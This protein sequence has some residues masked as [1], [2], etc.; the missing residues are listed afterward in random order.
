MLMFG[1][2]SAVLAGALAGVVAA[3][4][5]GVTG[6]DVGN[7]SVAAPEAGV[8]TGWEADA[9][10]AVVGTGFFGGEATTA[11]AG[12][13]AAGVAAVAVGAAAL[14]G[15][16]VPGGWPAGPVFSSIGVDAADVADVVGGTRSPV[17]WTQPESTTAVAR[18]RPSLHPGRAGAAL[19][20]RQSCSS[21]SVIKALRT[22]F[23]WL[24][25]RHRVGILCRNCGL[26]AFF[27]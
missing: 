12:A 26:F 7:G 15:A 1:K 25:R 27:R 19:P 11:G 24:Y 8:V 16:A 6:A 2:P 14:A 5:A 23:V 3:T 21:V 17:V 10:A 20:I 18:H 13:A 22:G 9:V 4:G